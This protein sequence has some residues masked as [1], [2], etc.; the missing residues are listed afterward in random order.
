MIHSSVILFGEDRIQIGKNVRI[1][2]YTVISAGPEGVFIG[3][4][5]HIG[6]GVQIF[7]NYG[8]VVLATFAT[9]SPRVTLLTGTDDFTEGHMVGPCIPEKY[10]KVQK[11]DI[12]I[13]R[14][15][16]V[17][18]GSVILP[19]VV[20][21]EGAVVGAL[22]LIKKDV[23]ECAIVVGTQQRQIG[24]RNKEL[25]KQLEQEYLHAIAK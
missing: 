20:M 5:V 19:G 10:R 24:M 25:L 16:I 9:L 7:G 1:D 3:D 23:P 14:H 13:G 21:G 11:G 4:N 12:V 17:G 18:C 22:S 2:C 8:K 6:S 15:A